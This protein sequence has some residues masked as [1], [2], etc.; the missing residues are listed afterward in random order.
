MTIH[1]G[2]AVEADPN[3]VVERKVHSLGWGIGSVETIP[4]KSSLAIYRRVYGDIST[5][6]KNLNS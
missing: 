1:H 2:P 5:F 4:K 3:C 6:T